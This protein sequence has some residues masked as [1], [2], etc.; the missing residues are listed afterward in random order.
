MSAVSEVGLRER[1]REKTRDALMRT[2]LQLFSERGFDHVTVEEIAA[3]YDLSARTFFRYFASKEDVLFS[4]GDRHRTHLLQALAEQA[5]SMGPFA[6]LEAALRLVAT[7]YAQERDLL[8]MRHQ[9]VAST[10][11]LSTRAAERKQGWEVEV[12]DLLRA[13]GRARGMSDVDL[14][15]VVAATTTALQVAIEAW[16]VS[17]DDADLDTLLDA[18]FERLRTGLGR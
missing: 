3:G 5:P 15:L 6:A 4:E 2:A 14:R 13:S 16:V 7:D 10:P 8:R 18:V 1:K 17:D 9:I 11:S 12:I